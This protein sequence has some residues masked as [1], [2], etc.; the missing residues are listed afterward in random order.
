MET[1]IIGYINFLY[2]AEKKLRYRTDGFKPEQY[3]MLWEFIKWATVTGKTEEPQ[4][5]LRMLQ[6]WVLLV[7][8]WIE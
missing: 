4:Y 2:M 8:Q 5:V 3:T 1:K 6:N 7:R